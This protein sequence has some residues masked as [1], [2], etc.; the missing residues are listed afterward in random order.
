MKGLDT[1]KSFMSA[2]LKCLE[3]RVCPSY[4]VG[5]ERHLAKSNGAMWNMFADFDY[6]VCGSEMEAL[7]LECSQIKHYMP[8]YKHSAEDDKTTPMSR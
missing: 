8:H 2:R 3:T 4:F 6:L 7:V 1:G 5:I